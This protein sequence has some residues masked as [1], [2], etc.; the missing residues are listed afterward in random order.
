VPVLGNDYVFKERDGVHV[1]GS[2]NSDATY[3][4]AATRVINLM[5]DQTELLTLRDKLRK[6]ETIISWDEV[7]KEWLKIMN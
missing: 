3:K 4:R 6:S 1:N 7:A 2:T 5:K